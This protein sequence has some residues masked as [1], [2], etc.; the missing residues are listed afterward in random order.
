MDIRKIIREEIER[1]LSES[2]NVVIKGYSND[3]LKDIYEIRS[4]IA[5][6]VFD[7]DKIIPAK[8][9]DIYNMFAIDGDMEYINFYLRNLPEEMVKKTLSYIKY[10][11][12]E[13]NID[14]KFKREKSG[15]EEGDV[16]RIMVDIPEGDHA[17]E[18]NLSNSNAAFIFQDVLNYSEDEMNDGINAAMLIAKIKNVAPQLFKYDAED[19][20]SNE[21]KKNVYEF[22]PGIDY[23]IRKL[24]QIQEI[25]EYA[26]EK[27]YQSILVF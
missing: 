13:H 22:K 18:L 8:E 15:S 1:F 17:P 12:S 3:D 25:A 10:M 14:V 21:K 24:E 23:I 27:G 6:W 26:I 2:M 11:L 19:S 20:Y 4:Q 9:Y 16:V 5:Y 7:K